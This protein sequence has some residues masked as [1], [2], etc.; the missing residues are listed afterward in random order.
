MASAFRK[1]NSTTQARMQ[2]LIF[3]LFQDAAEQFKKDAVH[4][5]SRP[6]QVRK[7]ILANLHNDTAIMP[8]FQYWH[9]IMYRNFSGNWATDHICETTASADVRQ[10]SPITVRLKS[11]EVSS[12]SSTAITAAS[13][14]MQ[15]ISTCFRWNRPTA[16]YTSR[17]WNDRGSRAPV[18]SSWRRSD[19]IHLH[20]TN[21]SVEKLVH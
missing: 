19:S 12:K 16:V 6:R 7:E 20:Y 13:W 1:S 4:I 3:V 15:R 5:F 2:T 18:E 14:F 10:P 17:I 21:R 11:H 9:S 8:G